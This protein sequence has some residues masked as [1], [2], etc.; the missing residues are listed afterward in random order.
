MNN[1]LL[2]RYIK[3]LILEDV[4]VPTTT[5]LAL[6]KTQKRSGIIAVIL[7]YDLLYKSLYSVNSDDIKNLEKYLYDVIKNCV[8]GYGEFGPLRDSGKAYGAWE[9]YKSAGPG[10]GKIIYGIG[11]ACSPKGILVPDRNSVSASASSFWKKEFGERQKLKLDDFFPY[12][13]TEEDEDDATLH[14]PSAEH[15]N[16]AYKSLGWEKPMVNKMLRMGSSLIQEIVDKFP[17]RLSEEKIINVINMIGNKFFE[18]VYLG[19][20]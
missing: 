3:L 11:Y 6:V 16:Y 10:Y 9:V 13:S 17:Y 12:N 19:L 15:L 20:G 14:D 4:G 2:R 8:V 7:R 1:G 18:D 5:T